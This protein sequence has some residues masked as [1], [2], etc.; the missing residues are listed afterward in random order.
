M[1]LYIT[2][3]CH[4][5]FSRFQKLDKA[6]ETAIIILGDAGLDFYL[7]SS[8]KKCKQAICN[9]Y[10]NF[11][12]YLVRGNHEERPS[13]LANIEIIFDNFVQGDVYFHTDFPQIRYFRDGNKYNIHG[14]SV[15]V[16]G[17][18]YSV[19]KWYRLAGRPEDTTHWTGWFKDEQLT[20]LEMF[21]IMNMM[22]NQHIDVVLSHTCP[23]DWRPTDLFLPT[24]DQSLVDDTMERWMNEL[25]EVMTWNLWLFGHYHDNRLVRPHVEMF[26]D[27][28]EEFDDVWARWNP[29]VD[30]EAVSWFKKDP[31]FFMEN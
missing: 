20:E 4:G 30:I 22:K 1:K 9:D 21:G 14:H 3:D 7:N 18:A 31:N 17:G 5:D 10:P 11:I 8:D 23:Y 26:F 24:I 13:K 27:Y 28:I 25:K 15:L 29:S 19:D 16:L 6:Q 12:F 2:G